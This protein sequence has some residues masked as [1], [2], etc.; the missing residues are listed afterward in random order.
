MYAVAIVHTASYQCVSVWL[1]PLWDGWNTY[2]SC[3][4][5]KSA[6]YKLIG[7]VCVVVAALQRR[8]WDS[9]CTMLSTKAR[10]TPFYLKLGN[11]IS[12]VQTHAG[13]RVWTCLQ[14]L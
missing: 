14:K 12:N 7:L 5:I 10:V 8:V 13:A 6:T 3:Y 11:G 1:S 2:I 4:V 9:V